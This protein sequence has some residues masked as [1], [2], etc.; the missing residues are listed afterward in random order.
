MKNRKTVMIALAIIGTLLITAG[1]TIA[2]FSYSKYGIGENSVSAG[3]IKFIYNEKEGSGIDLSDAMPMSDE[4]GMAQ[5]KYFD[6][7]V[8]GTTGDSVILYEITARKTDDSDDIGNAVKLA[9]AK[10]N[11]EY[12]AETI[13]AYGSY[14]PEVVPTY[15]SLSNSTNE[16]ASINHEKTL[17]KG[18]IG[19]NKSNYVDNYRL[20]MWLNNNPNYG[21]VLE[22]TQ[23]ITSICSNTT[24]TT[25][26]ECVSNGF[27]WV[28]TA[29]A[30][31]KTFKVKINVYSYVKSIDD[32]EPG[33][34]DDDYNLVY[35]WQELLDMEYINVSNNILYGS[36]QDKKSK[37]AG[38][39]I[40]ADGITTIGGGAFTNCYNLKSV[41]I[42]EGVTEIQS[43]AFLSCY[44][45]ERVKLP[46]SL[47][48]IW[49]FAFNNCLKLQDINFNE[50]LVEIINNAFTNNM[51][52]KEI[53]IPS[54]TT[55]IQ[56]QAF[57]GCTNLEKVT[58]AD[59]VTYLGTSAF[60]D[61][62]KLK[63]VKLSNSITTMSSMAFYRDTALERVILPNNLR[64]IQ[65]GVFY[66]CASLK[67]ISI[68]ATLNRIEY[69][70]FSGTGLETANFAETAGWKAGD[71]DI[72]ASDLANS[73]TAAEYL[74]TTYIGKNWIRSE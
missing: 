1:A 59:G 23:T 12:L 17:Y 19:K 46:E 55:T 26:E 5:D 49:M 37:L 28:D 63:D 69:G 58:M 16:I 33:L 61:C 43:S 66:D 68:P 30:N 3:T 71:I 10:N 64:E 21:N 7:S 25:A 36:T 8:K 54:T 9:L 18:I 11:D 13:Q 39:L 48:T 73:T 72:L 27:D 74:K 52:L 60:M 22:S 4:Q 6:F 45:L 34:Y 56:S 31:P 65:S 44:N 20:R 42:P 29:E 41:V 14:R 32:L 2:F 40:I 47:T 62:S 57:M 70:A 15:D 53:S 50:G 38:N 24:Y 67:T 51:S 35:S